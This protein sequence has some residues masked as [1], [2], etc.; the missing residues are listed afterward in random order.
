MILT[1]LPPAT[2]SARIGFP[3][4]LQTASAAS[5]PSCSA[6]NSPNCARSRTLRVDGRSPDMDTFTLAEA[7]GKA[8]EPYK[9]TGNERSTNQCGAWQGEGLMTPDSVGDQV[10]HSLPAAVRSGGPVTSGPAS[11]RDNARGCATFYPRPLSPVAV[12]G[13]TVSGGS[14]DISVDARGGSAA[15]QDPTI[16]SRPRPCL[17]Y[18]DSLHT[19]SHGA[20]ISTASH[21]HV[22]KTVGEERGRAGLPTASTHRHP[23][24][25]EPAEVIRRAPQRRRR[26]DC[27]RPARSLKRPRDRPGTSESGSAKRLPDKEEVPGS[28]PGTPT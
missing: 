3:S 2:Q 8:G 7:A 26:P 25:R 13:R 27:R 20:T 21:G 18:P 1:T 15:I 11:E 14:V 6:Y 24:H 22:G 16:T 19:A 4:A 23:S 28:N 9:S 17:R 10:P 5:N 12:Q